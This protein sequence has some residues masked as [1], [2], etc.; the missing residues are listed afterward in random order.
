[1]TPS[2]TRIDSVIHSLSNAYFRKKATPSTSTI[3][4]T[5]NIRRPP[6]ASS[7][8]VDSC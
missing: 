1:M 7:S 8:D 4:P 2:A 5:H 3:A 6:I